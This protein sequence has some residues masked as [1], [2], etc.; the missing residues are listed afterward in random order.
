M[1]HNERNVLWIHPQGRM[2]T[3]GG[4][5]GGT[6]PS[7]I[8]WNDIKN[9]P[10]EFK[11]EKHTHI[12]TDVENLRE[13]LDFLEVA[14]DKNNEKLVQVEKD[15]SNK[16][17]I[18]EGK[19]LST[20]DFTDELKDKL[21][22]LQDGESVVLSVN[23]QTGHVK[24]TKEDIE[25]GNVLNVTQAT[26]EEFNAFKVE[27][28]QALDKK[29]DKKQGYQLS[30]ENFT[31]L[32]KTKLKNLPTSDKLVLSVNEQTGHIVID[33]D[34]IGLGNVQDI[35]QA[36][37]EDL[38]KLKLALTL[39]QK[40]M[41]NKVDKVDGKGLSTNDFTDDYKE[42]LDSIQEGGGEGGG[43]L[44]VGKYVESVNGKSGKITLDNTWVGLDNVLNIRQVTH[45]ELDATV[46]MING[47]LENKVNKVEGKGLSEAN[48]TQAEKEKLAKLDPEAQGVGEVISVN[49][50]KGVV[51]L[52]KD[53]V[54]LGNVL[55]EKQATKVE[56]D[57][58]AKRVDENKEALE[59]KVDKVEGK[60]LSS[61]D[62]TDDFK[63][64]L[65]KLPSSSNFV[66]SVNERTGNVVL[67]KKDVHLD[68]VLNVEQASKTEHD[69]LAERVGLVEVEVEDKVDKREGYDLS[70]NDFTDEYKK[71][72]DE[73]SESKPVEDYVSSV[74]GETGDVAI[75]KDTLELG[76][77]LNVE[78]ASKEEFDLLKE[79]VES[80]KGALDTKVDEKEGYGLSQENFSPEL[81][82]KLEGLEEGGVIEPSGDYVISINE[83]TG[84]VTLD[85]D[86]IGLDKVDNVKQA[87]KEEFDEFKA[88]T[89]SSL[90]NKVD[91]EVGKGLSSNDYTVEDK[92]LVG[93]IPDIQ[94]TLNDNKE[95]IDTKANDE[96]VNIAL[97]NKVDKEDG[98]GL[99]T[100][101]FTDEDKTNIAALD[102]EVERILELLGEGEEVP[103]DGV[104]TVI[105]KGHL[106]QL[107]DVIYDIVNHNAVTGS[108]ALRFTLDN[109]SLFEDEDVRYNRFHV[110]AS[111]QVL[112][113]LDTANQM[114]SDFDGMLTGI[115]DKNRHGTLQL[116]VNGRSSIPEG[117]SMKTKYIGNNFHFHIHDKHLNGMGQVTESGSIK[118]SII[119]EVF[120]EDETP[121]GS[122]FI[123]V[124]N[125]VTNNEIY[126]HHFYDHEI[127]VKSTMHYDAIEAAKAGNL[128]L[129]G[130]LT[131]NTIVVNEEAKLGTIIYENKNAKTYLELNNEKQGKETA[132]VRVTIAYNTLTPEVARRFK[133]EFVYLSERNDYPDTPLF[134]NISI[135][136]YANMAL[137]NTV[138]YKMGTNEINKDTKANTETPFDTVGL[139]NT[140]IVENLSQ[141]T[142]EMMHEGL[143]V[144]VLDEAET[145]GETEEPTE[146][147][148]PE[149]EETEE[150]GDS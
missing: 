35:E 98:K 61:N 12:I 11:P 131:T 17:D 31:T 19:G 62:F 128:E 58:L 15:V 23:D 77:V 50:K 38:E 64:K 49:G 99:S 95:L 140:V 79:V 86:D 74:N 121:I 110:N 53:D 42:K 4:E 37:K 14:I 43:E 104:L 26:E 33:K 138:N 10:S 76:N 36:S 117:Q 107:G 67:T 78:Q 115:F 133:D 66:T 1:L 102:K 20:N 55:N 112:N 44:P 93:S 84:V 73:L 137:E 116:T 6:T 57:T 148:T 125:A 142:E 8:T 111:G 83:K 119:G 118:L 103:E 29:V 105:K 40:E 60:E 22:N 25:L 75:D 127:T 120:T 59:K 5:G 89:T 54:G 147:E 48:F 143:I 41:P 130:D 94:L 65:E 21:E 34:S 24:I 51:E 72:I 145:E 82:R 81:K 85:K 106:Y 56:H 47:L 2:T 141:V 28:E 45:D 18:E 30:Q 126:F 3:N 46:E 136:H 132:G 92:A 68:N 100:N 114:E 69:A 70:S 144:L 27:M 123:S 16:V 109:I 97:N 63:D 39:L 134:N 146:P 129:V 87:T 108:L 139:R 71:K 13:T 122:G 150:K 88:D 135:E 90:N 80:N 124:R 101:D 96:E 113:Y 52:D 7:Y 9:K 32:E 91:K 149:G